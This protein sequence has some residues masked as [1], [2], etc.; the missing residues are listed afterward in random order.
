MIHEFASRAELAAALADA[1][2]AALS[3]R[4]R[5]QDTVWL[6]VSGGSTPQN[7]FAELSRR[8]LDWRRV[9]VTPVD[10][11]W[12]PEEHPRSNAALIRRLLL[13]ETAAASRFVPF[14]D[15]A[16]T[17][18][19]GRDALEA[20]LASLPL[21]LAAAVLGMGEDGHTAS[22]FPG[23][24]RLAAALRPPPGRLVE[25]MRAAGAGEPR[26]TLTLPVLAAAGFLALHIEGEAKR[27]VLRRA[28][29]PGPD[30][31]MPVRALLR[32]DPHIFWSP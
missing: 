20:R 23:G 10:E 9:T 31:E 3:A 4:L 24:D 30:E 14:Y 22:F 1:V 2:A 28:A 8:P 21:P 25:T 16:R 19:A 29:A 12:V 18:E 6:A 32:H 13:R 27:Q 5:T 17:P 11:R 15:G 26:M 7:F